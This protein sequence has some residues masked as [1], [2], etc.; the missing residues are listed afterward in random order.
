ML[1]SLKKISVGKAISILHYVAI[2]LMIFL[3]VYS[4]L[5]WL[6]TS[7]VWGFG[8]IFWSS[9]TTFALVYLGVAVFLKIRAVPNVEGFVISSTSTVSMIWLYEIIYH[10]SFWDSWNYGAYPFFFPWNEC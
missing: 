10:F 4:L 1:T 2:L 7:N 6:T 9:W 5:A 3:I 8:D